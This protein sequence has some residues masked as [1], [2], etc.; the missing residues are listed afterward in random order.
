MAKTAVY[1]KKAVDAYRAKFDFIQV[2]LDKGEKE[3]I[4]KIIAPEK[5][6]EYAK[7]LIYESLEREEK[8]D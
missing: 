3:R 2:R 1:T 5:I 6:G 8:S 4:E 7:K